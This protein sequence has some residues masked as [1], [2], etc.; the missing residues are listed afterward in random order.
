[1]ISAYICAFARNNS[2]NRKICD[3]WFVNAYFVQED[4]LKKEGVL[5]VSL[6]EISAEEKRIQVRKAAVAGFIGTA[7][8]WY[9]FFLYGTASALIF[10]KLFFPDSDPYVGILQS[11]T[12]FFLGFLARPVGAAI[13]GHY[14]DRIGRKATLII[15]LMLMGISSTIIGFLPTYETVGTL[16]PVLLVLLRVCQGIGVGGEWGG[17]VLLSMEWG[18]KERRGLMA[19]WSQLGVPAGLL[20]SSV[21]VS[22]FL[23]LTGPSFNSWGWRVPFLLSIVLVAIGLYIRLGILESPMFAMVKTEM[24]VA[25][26]PVHEVIKKHPKEIILSALVRLSEQA[27]FYIFI[28]FVIS[29]CTG[30]LKMDKQFVSNAISVASVLSLISVPYFG[31]LSDKI[32]RKKMYMIGS[33]ITLLFAFPY[34]GMLNSGIPALVFLAIVLSLIPHDMQY[35]PQ[36]ALIAE[37]FPTHLRYSGSSLGYQLASIIAGGPAPLIAAYLLHQF[38]TST[39]ISV[40]LIVVSIISIIATSMLKGR[41]DQ[42]INKEYDA[43]HGPVSG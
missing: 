10:P 29:Y 6:N 20:L 3:N 17:S 8:E 27:P 21:L 9:D 40:Y 39:A 32:G 36:A 22:L 25:R 31:H 28:T 7:I 19:S 33:F 23:N 1:V 34:F 30:Q 11:F 43:A 13:F 14:G 24:K 15:T 38:G 16:A 37:N 12:T 35:G 18:S 2:K 41:S 26:Q 5:S 42:E 4:V